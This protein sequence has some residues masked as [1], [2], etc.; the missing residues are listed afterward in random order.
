[1][2][3]IALI[4]LALVLAGILCGC[5]YKDSVI[6]SLIK[7]ESKEFYTS[8]GFQD[9]TDYAK[10]VYTSAA[11]QDLEDSEYFRLMTAEDVEEILS[12]I[13]NFEMWVEIIGGDLQGNYDFN[14]GVISE[15]DFLCI[16][17]GGGAYSGQFDSYSVYFFDTEVQTLYYFHN[18][19]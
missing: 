18:N 13:E 11:V 14:K 7:Y 15:G 1:M 8:G 9:Y 19:I 3:R 10:Y 4:W 16:K 17:T 6:E 5:S 2:K 12:Y